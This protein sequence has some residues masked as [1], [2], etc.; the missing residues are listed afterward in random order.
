MTMRPTLRKP[1]GTLAIL[2]LIALW[3]IL[4]AS[5]SAEIGRLNILAQTAIYVISGIAWIAPLKPMLRWMETGKW[6]E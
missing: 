3:V 1:V 2:L 4:I 6:R 5:F